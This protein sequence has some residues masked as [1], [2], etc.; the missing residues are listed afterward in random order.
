MSY[1][2]NQLTK[3]LKISARKEETSEA[4]SLTFEIPEGHEKEFRFQPGQFVTL[5]LPIDGEILPR[6]YS[7]CSSPAIDREL[8]ITIKRVPGG[9]GSNYICDHL[10]VGDSVRVSPPSGR[11]FQPPKAVAPH[12]Y[13]LAAAGSGI[14]PIY[15]IMKTV[16]MTDPTAKVTLLFGNRNENSIIYATELKSWQTRMGERLTIHHVL[17]QPPSGWSGYSGRIEGTLLT[18]LLLQSLP[19]NKAQVEAYVCGPTGFMAEVV[20]NLK[21]RGVTDAQ[22][23][24]ESFVTTTQSASER[25]MDDSSATYI[26]DEK[27][28]W[29]G[30]LASVEVILSGETIQLSVAKDKT[31]LESLIENG[32][33]PPYSCLEGNCM[34]CM[35]KVRAGRVVQRDPGILLD[36]NIASGDVLTCQARPASNHIKIDYDSI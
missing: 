28:P 13:L 4:V 32:S 5:F 34:A 2:L 9:R 21:A 1:D 11:F 18:G 26:G 16:L 25:P 8:K 35:A 33:N 3:P 15:S 29:N 24:Q 12:H 10:K 36:E 27:A 31:I 19:T 7:I 14:T 6:S 30:G 22:I 20:A 23:H 17:T